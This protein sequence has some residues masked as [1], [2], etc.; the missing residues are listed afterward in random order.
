MNRLINGK[1][2]V[3]EMLI[4]G[5]YVAVLCAKDCTFNI[6]QDVIEVTSINSV[7]TREYLP[8]MSSATLTIGGVSPIDNTEGKVSILYLMQQSVRQ[9]VQKWRITFTADD[10][11]NIAATFD[12]VVS[13]TDITRSGFAYNQSSVQVKVSGAITMDAIIDPPVYNYDI[14][15]DYWTTTAGF[16][17]VGLSGSSAINSY[18]IGATDTLLQVDVEGVQFDLITSGTP[19][20]RE[21]KLNTTTFVLTFATDFIFDG[22]QRVYVMF[23]RG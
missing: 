1:N 11:T 21:C 9:I 22:T 6:S 3:A 16:N 23:K 19:G 10:G 8:G 2:I 17:Y 12:G 14:L 7:S 5:D 13:T 20:N 15:S 4:S 18:M